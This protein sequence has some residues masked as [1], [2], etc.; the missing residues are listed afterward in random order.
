M[1]SV[2]PCVQE[3][4]LIVTEAYEA[5]LSVASLRMDLSL[6]GLSTTNRL[7]LSE[8][9]G[10]GGDLTSTSPPSSAA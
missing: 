3:F 6:L 4:A 5:G 9:A 1:T 8:Q 10:G 7:G 2:R